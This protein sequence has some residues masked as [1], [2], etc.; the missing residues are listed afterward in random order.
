MHF[1]LKDQVKGFKLLRLTS[2]S[3]GINITKPLV[4]E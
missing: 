4:F 1:D 3:S 2:A